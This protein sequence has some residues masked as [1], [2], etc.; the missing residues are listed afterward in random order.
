MTCVTRRCD[1]GYAEPTTRQNH[2]L[3]RKRLLSSGITI[4]STL[5]FAATA[6]EAMQPRTWETL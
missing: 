5:G 4:P 3:S 6:E 1:R 2:C